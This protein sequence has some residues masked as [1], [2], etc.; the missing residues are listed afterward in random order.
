A[1]SGR[2]VFSDRLRPRPDRGYPD[3]RRVLEADFTALRTPGEYRVRVAGLGVSFPFFIDDGVAAAFARTYAL[4]IYHQRCGTSNNLP[5]TRF[6]HGACHTARAE[7]PA[8]SKKFEAVNE[9]LQKETANYKDN[10]RHTARQLKDVNSSL[11]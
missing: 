8:M 7:V 9:S 2:E 11:Y 10:P 3:Y 5:F 6:S 1:D 4:G